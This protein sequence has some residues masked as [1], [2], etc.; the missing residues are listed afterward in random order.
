MENNQVVK[1]VFMALRS[2]LNCPIPLAF[3]KGTSI[4]YLGYSQ[5]GKPMQAHPERCLAIGPFIRQR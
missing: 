2:I 5:A 4:I 3:V 1:V